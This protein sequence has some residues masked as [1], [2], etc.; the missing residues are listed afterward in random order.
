MYRHLLALVLVLAGAAAAAQPAGRKAY[1]VQLSGPPAATYS[2]GVAGLA[3]TRAAPGGTFR[4]GAPGVR[5]Y[6]SHLDTRR[7]QVLAGVAGAQVLHRYGVAF[8]GFSALLSD[9]DVQKL[10]ATPGVLAVRRDLP[11]SL[12]TSRTPIF[13]GLSTPGGLWSQVD[14]ASRPLKGED[15]VVGV[16]DSGIWPEDPSFSD[17]VDANGDPVSAHQPGRVVYGPPPARWSGRCQSGP[18]FGPERCNHKVIGARYFDASFKASGLPLHWAEYESPRDQDGHGSHTASI[19]AGNAGVA[20]RVNGTDTGRIAG[21][22]PRAR[23]AIYKACWSW[24]DL[25]TDEV[26]VNCWIGDSVAAIEQAVADGVDVINFSIGGSTD[27]LL[28]PV[29]EAFLNAT[30][31]GVFVATA[32]GNEGPGNTVSHPAPWLTTVAAS[33]HDRRLVAPVQLGNGARLQGASRS[34]GVPSKPLVL[35]TAVALYPPFDESNL[36]ARLC[37][38]DALDP[39]KAAGKIIVCDRGTNARVEKSE[40]AARVGAAGM[41][42]LNVEPSDLLD[43]PHFVPT[44]HLPH[45]D[46]ATVRGYAVSADASA[47]LGVAT[48]AEGV[49]AP[50]VAEFSS[51]GPNLA[52]P[53][54]VK[55]DLSAPGVNLLAAFAWQPAT[56]A[57]HAAVVAGTLTPPPAADFLSGTSMA[58][59]HVAG[60]AAL[61]KQRHP[62]WSPAAIKSVLLTSAGPLRTP[63]GGV[64]GDRW[65]YG[66]GHLNPRAAAATSLVYEAGLADYVGFLCGLDLLPSDGPRCSTSL[67][68]AAHN[69]NLPSLGATVVG[70]LEVQREVRHLG[71]SPATY[72]ADA[73]LPGFAVAVVPAQLQLAPGERARFKVQLLRTSAPSG[74]WRFG[75]LVWRNGAGQQVLSPIVARA[76]TLDAPASFDDTRATGTKVFN[77]A[78]GY[79]G[80][81]ETVPLGLVPA[82]RQSGVVS[83]G[84]VTCFDVPVATGA[85]HARFALFDSDSSGG[86]ADDLDLEVYLDEALVGISAGATADEEVRLSD[87]APGQYSACVVGYAPQG[88]RASFTLSS[89]VV[90]PQSGTGSLRAS[91]PRHVHLGGNA[92]VGLGWSV[93]TG[94]RYLGAV[95]FRDGRGTDL[96][97][98]VLSVDTLS[99]TSRSRS[100][101]ARKANA[102]SKKR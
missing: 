50:V 95:S 3:A 24:L 19:A 27:D 85:R 76:L 77:V 57:Q 43:D 25:A 21:M 58:S 17:K 46:A 53:L 66:A 71:T 96:G 54:I 101:G 28:D 13:L 89:W 45:T 69:L 62:T 42:L 47:A 78:T 73:K 48:Q 26:V 6:L 9:A 102:L 88:G 59:P 63:E 39:A 18:G 98:T 38:L 65:G 23:L 67:P 72:V 70:R 90:G 30:A 100:G 64:D 75:S 56:Q 20:T 74:E 32:G 99:T 31:A 33:T 4:L 29:E 14:A 91:G 79:S 2:G 41:I 86:G 49:V 92:S 84:G 10:K 93:G 40:E 1:I 35:S 68:I 80:V 44:V 11:R 87:P 81:L 55:P 60:V 16:I 61:L 5:A 34:S 22:A 8:N 15:V 12:A 37:F 94:Q 36:D 82:T 51:R 83:S 7:N 52:T 97:T